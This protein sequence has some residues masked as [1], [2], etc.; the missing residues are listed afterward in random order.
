MVPP[1]AFP[2]GM[3]LALLRRPRRGAG[4]DADPLDRGA[5]GARVP[6]ILETD[7]DRILKLI[8]SEILLLYTAVI[9]ASSD[10]AWPHFGLVLVGIGAALA[11]LILYLDGR[12]TGQ[13]APW[14]Q[15]VVRT[16]AFVACALAIAWPLPGWAAHD[17]RWLRSLSVLA[18]P[19]AGALL[20]RDRAPAGPD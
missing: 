11:P 6:P 2:A 4:A 3:P 8:P 9:P 14:P 7:L 13:P 5:P 12:S 15:Y 17:L 20:L 1:L 18:I 19:F 10:V 16:L